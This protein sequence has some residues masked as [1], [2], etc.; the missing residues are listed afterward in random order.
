MLILYDIDLTNR[1]FT[2]KDEEKKQLPVLYK[3][4]FLCTNLSINTLLN[5]VKVIKLSSIC[6]V[7]GF[8]FGINI[9]L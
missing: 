2:E 9:C 5:Q 8:F 3:S 1:A 6:I 7:K 4:L